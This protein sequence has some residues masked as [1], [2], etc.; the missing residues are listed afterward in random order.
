[1]LRIKLFL[2]KS[3]LIVADFLGKQ[4]KE[5]SV[6]VFAGRY[7]DI[8]IYPKM[9]EKPPHLSVVPPEGEQSES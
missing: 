7:R 4:M 8:V 1:M 2:L 9:T 3:I 6:V 5:D